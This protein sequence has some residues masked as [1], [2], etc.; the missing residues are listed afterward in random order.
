M[1]A[2][3]NSN[4][5]KFAIEVLPLIN[6]RVEFLLNILKTNR[7]IKPKFCKHIIIDYIYV[8]N[9]NYCFSQIF[10]RVTTLV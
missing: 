4:F 8:G 10:N 7:P 9:V 1:K 3:M 2:R 5:G 6:V